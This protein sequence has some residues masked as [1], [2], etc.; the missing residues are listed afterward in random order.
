[1]GREYSHQGHFSPL[2]LFFL[3]SLPLWNPLPNR[4]KSTWLS[5]GCQV[6]LS[7]PFGC[8]CS[9]SPPAHPVT[10][11]LAAQARALFVGTEIPPLNNFLLSGNLPNPDSDI[12]ANLHSGFVCSA[13]LRASPSERESRIR[14]RRVYGEPPSL[15][16]FGKHD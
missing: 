3:P 8:H 10:H 2:S 14:G 5:A 12:F 6:I 16:R 7:A 1:M 4:F 11:S 9:G 15:W 13:L